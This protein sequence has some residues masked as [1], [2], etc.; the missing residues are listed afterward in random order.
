MPR[1][2]TEFS[3]SSILDEEL[4]AIYN[5]HE[6]NDGTL[7]EDYR[8]EDKIMLETG[9][10]DADQIFFAMLPVKRLSCHGTSKLSQ[11]TSPGR[12]RETDSASTSHAS[13]TYLLNVHLEAMDAATPH[14]PPLSLFGGGI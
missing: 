13:R 14:D 5:Y 7:D 10:F 11:K 9:I 3:M 2:E 4:M 6:G 8:G 1:A 12:R